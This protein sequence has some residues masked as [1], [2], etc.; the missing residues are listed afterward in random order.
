M[1]SYWRAEI[2]LRRGVV[3]LWP[4]GEAVLPRRDWGNWLIADAHGPQ[5]VGDGSAVDPIPITD[6]LGAWP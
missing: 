6:Q 1:K 4:F 5:P 3:S 2:L